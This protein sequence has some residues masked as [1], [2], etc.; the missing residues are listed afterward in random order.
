MTTR[1]PGRPR[2]ATRREAAL[3]AARE[4]LAED[5]YAAVTIAGVAERAGVARTTIYRSWPTKGALVLDAVTELMDL[6]P[7]AKSGDWHADLLAAIEGSMRA[8]SR[9]VAGRTIP[10]LAVDLSRDPVL[11]EEFRTRFAQPRKR[12]VVNLLERGVELGFVR[13]DVDLDLVED[14]L[15][16]PI[17]HRLAVTG[18]PVTESMVHDLVG[19]VVKAVA[20]DPLRPGAAADTF[21]PG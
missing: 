20:P 13:H 6:G 15:V 3:Q 21:Q 9:S 12:E 10:A 1:G 8:L 16:A 17:V 19:L 4:I 14:I 5:G 18:A 2:D 7:A 11:A